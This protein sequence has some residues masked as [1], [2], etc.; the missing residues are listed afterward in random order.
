M[1]YIF[2]LFGCNNKTN[3]KRGFLVTLS[4]VTLGKEVHLGTG[5]ASL[6]SAMTLVLGKKAPFAEC[7]VVHSAKRQAKGPTGAPFAKH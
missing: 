1:I 4:S 7:L 6:P 3:K 2:C 5:K